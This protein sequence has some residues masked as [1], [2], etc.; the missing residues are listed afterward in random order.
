MRRGKFYLDIAFLII[1]MLSVVSCREDGKYVD[2]SYEQIYT[3][4]Q[5]ALNGSI[6]EYCA[7][8]DETSDSESRMFYLAQDTSFTFKR[9]ER[10]RF[11]KPE[12]E[13]LC[14]MDLRIT[15]IQVYAV[16][17]FDDEHPAGSC[18]NDKLNVEYYYKDEIV[19]YPLSDI[20]AKPIMLADYY[21]YAK[22]FRSNI[23]FSVIDTN[24]CFYP[25]EVLITDGFGNTIYLTPEI[26]Q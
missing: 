26:N 23:S 7:E 19:K 17:K 21:P 10:I 20:D 12:Y 24:D 16:D 3:K 8:Y 4:A 13:T 25:Y 18:V 6:I 5:Y 2:V 1:I 22:P 14:A 11:N 15:D 9:R